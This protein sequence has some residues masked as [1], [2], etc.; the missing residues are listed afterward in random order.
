LQKIMEPLFH[1]AVRR[2][3]SAFEKRAAERYT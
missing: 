1:E 2:M 3:V